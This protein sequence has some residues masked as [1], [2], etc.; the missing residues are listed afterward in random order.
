MSKESMRI[1]RLRVEQ[2][3][4]EAPL[5]QPDVGYAE[6]NMPE[7]KCTEF[8]EKDGRHS[9]FHAHPTFCEIYVQ[10]SGAARYQFGETQWDVSCGDIL[11]FPPNL[12]HRLVAVTTAPGRRIWVGIGNFVLTQAEELVKDLNFVGFPDLNRPFLLRAS[13][14]TNRELSCAFQQLNQECESEQPGWEMKA[15]CAAVCLIVDLARAYYDQNASPEEKHQCLL[16]RICRHIDRHLSEPLTRASICKQFFISPSTLSHL[17]H[18]QLGMPFSEYITIKRMELASML[19]STGKVSPQEVWQLCG[20]SE[21]SSFFRAFKK[22]YGCC[23]RE[24]RISRS[25][26]N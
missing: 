17:F 19:L 18:S 3:L 11:Y 2:F 16:E 9:L 1:N 14:F 20:Y 24:W 23:P 4:P 22:R 15:R 13:D 10:T 5:N 25:Q 12:P 21:Y 26:S 6:Q 7:P 8:S